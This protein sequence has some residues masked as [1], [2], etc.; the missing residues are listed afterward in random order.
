MVGNGFRF[1]RRPNPSTVEAIAYGQSPRIRRDSLSR[2]ERAGVRGYKLSIGPNPLTPTLSPPNSDL[3]EFGDLKTWPKSDISDFGAGRG[4]A[5]CH[6]QSP[7][8]RVGILP[9]LPR[10]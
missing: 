3:S 9:R 7:C 6:M 5:P 10:P 8:F 1:P 2:R 4:S